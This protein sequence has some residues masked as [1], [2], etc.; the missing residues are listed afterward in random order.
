L[1]NKVISEERDISLTAAEHGTPTQR[2]WIKNDRPRPSTRGKALEWVERQKKT[3]KLTRESKGTGGKN[4]ISREFL[5]CVGENEG[6]N[7]QTRGEEG[8]IE[9]PRIRGRVISE[10]R[11]RI[12][13]DE[14]ESGKRTV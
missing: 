10:G 1:R 5:V 11:K 12:V 14:G 3:K 13:V 8:G 9:G 6:W 4:R 7:L 2:A